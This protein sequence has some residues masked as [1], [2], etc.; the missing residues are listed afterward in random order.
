MV[1]TRKPDVIG[2][3]PTNRDFEKMRKIE[4]EK[5]PEIVPMTELKAG[6]EETRHTYI[7]YKEDNEVYTHLRLNIFPGMSF[8]R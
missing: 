3:A 4:S 8:L 1:P 7:P 5:W 2:R 6:Y